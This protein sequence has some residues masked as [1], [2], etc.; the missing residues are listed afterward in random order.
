MCSHCHTTSCSLLSLVVLSTWVGSELCVFPC[1]PVQSPLSP[2]TLT[3]PSTHPPLP[4]STLPPPTSYPPPP[5][6]PLPPSTIHPPSDPTNY[7]PCSPLRP[8][9]RLLPPDRVVPPPP[10]Y[11]A[12]APA[13]QHL[14]AERVL[15]EQSKQWVNRA[16]GLLEGGPARLADVEALLQ[17]AEMYLWGTEDMDPVR[18]MPGWG[19]GGGH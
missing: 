16:S 12:A 11:P 18:C 7:L 2:P 3:P 5:S 13:G 6:P 17:E 8:P 19:V 4:P 14:E 15:A 10:L 9:S 1:P